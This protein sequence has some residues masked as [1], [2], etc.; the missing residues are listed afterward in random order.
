MSSPSG[1]GPQQQSSGA[2]TIALL[3]VAICGVT[4]LVC[5]GGLAVLGGIAYTRLEKAAV[6]MQKGVRGQPKASVV[7]QQW[8]PDVIAR[9]QLTPAYTAALDAVATDK[10]V[11]EKLG[12][13]IEPAGESDLLYR[14]E[15]TSEWDGTDETIEFEVRGPKGEAVVRVVA[16]V[17]TTPAAPPGIYGGGARA[18][19]ITVVL[20]EGTEIVVPPPTEKTSP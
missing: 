3:V 15:K 8:D 19:S 1:Q 6:D 13:P 16:G 10:Q 2:W 20:T 5:C 17:P 11:L 12:A 7:M 18:K 9:M 4:L 14:R